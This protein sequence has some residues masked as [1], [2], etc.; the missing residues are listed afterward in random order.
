MGSLGTSEA[1]LG[2]VNPLCRLPLVILNLLVFCLSFIVGIVCVV[3]I[4]EQYEEISFRN[5]PL[6]VSFIVNLPI[7]VLVVSSVLLLIS[8][9]GYM[10][11]LRENLCFLAC[12]QRGLSLLM[13]LDLCVLA[14]CVLIPFLSRNSVQNLFTIDLI[15]SYRDNPDYA[16]LVDYTQTSFLCC[17][18]TDARYLDWNHNIYFNCSQ[19][20]PSKERCSVP[21]SCCRPPQDERL[22]TR[23]Q[24]RF[25]GADVLNMTEQEAWQKIYTRN[26]VDAS[27]AY[28]RA[29]VFLIVGV[30]LVVYAVL[31]LL[32]CM[33]SNVGEQIND[34]MLAYGAY[35]EQREKAGRSRSPSLSFTS[36]NRRR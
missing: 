31:Y 24:R 22:E 33:A 9:V 28:I 23:L 7:P 11:A 4:V 35:Y 18:V 16:R 32:Q 30:V 26:C 8:F 12:Y 14:V 19:W 6:L 34:L 1:I 5:R 27:V 25:C 29:N 17:G 21:A 10:G 2:D 13:C 3:T 36:E 15:T 20:S